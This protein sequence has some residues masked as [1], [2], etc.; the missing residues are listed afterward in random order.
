MNSEY[1]EYM[2]KRKRDVQCENLCAAY[3]DKYF[4]SRLPTMTYERVDGSLNEESKQR[5]IVGEDV[6][7][8]D[9]NG[10]VRCVI[11][12]KAKIQGHL[13]DV[14]T[15]PSFEIIR[16]PIPDS[17]HTLGWFSHPVSNTT[18][19]AM[20]S[21]GTNREVAP[22][23]EYTLN[24]S[25]ITCAVYGLICKKDLVA[26]VKE[27]TFKSIEEITNDA[28]QL[29][30]E[31]KTNPQRQK[32]G[33]VKVYRQDWRGKYIHLKL[34]ATNDNQPVNLVIRRDVLR[35]DGLI[36][37]YY[38]DEKRAVKYKRPTTFTIMG[39]KLVAMA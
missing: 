29:F 36:K 17:R 38:I 18:H 11:D 4:Y 15:Y 23:Q 12:E 35:N 14:L 22:Y 8:R 31:W 16:R 21:I 25:D 33:A 19:Y 9:A 39:E 10:N 26:W 28:Y 7:L 20:I 6:V 34:S 37:E 13:N 30:H 27:Q 24:E 2:N 5:Q 32:W 1:I 3:V